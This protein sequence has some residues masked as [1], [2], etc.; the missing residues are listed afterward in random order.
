MSPRSL[1][2]QES[3]ANPLA[4]T[5]TEPTI[6]IEFLKVE[7][8]GRSKV[9]L[10]DLAEMM[11]CSARYVHCRNHDTYKP[12]TNVPLLCETK[13]HYLNIR[14]LSGSILCSP[15]LATGCHIAHLLTSSNTPGFIFGGKS[16]CV[17]LTTRTFESH[18]RSRLVLACDP[19]FVFACVK[20]ASIDFIKLA[21][22]KFRRCCSARV[23]K[24]DSRS[25]SI[26]SAKPLSTFLPLVPVGLIS[27]IPLNIEVLTEHF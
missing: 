1:F 23:S 18:S 14:L 9:K 20:K 21:G 17:V 15:I 27:I 16:G 6:I 2:N 8:L 7:F 24:S 25:L 5:K 19:R 10:E 3:K 26:G 13:R 11:R 4:I 12:N 22:S